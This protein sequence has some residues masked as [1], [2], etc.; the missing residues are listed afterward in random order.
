MTVSMMEKI[1]GACYRAFEGRTDVVV[2]SADSFNFVVTINETEDSYR[3]TIDDADVEEDETGDG[4]KL[5]DFALAEPKKIIDH[6]QIL[7]VCL[8]AM[9]ADA[10]IKEAVND[11]TTD[12]D[13]SDCE[14]IFEAGDEGYLKLKVR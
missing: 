6:T 1:I 8:I 7:D 13:G 9:K 2:E 5:S 3:V 12:G 14:A 10:E 11:L 4:R